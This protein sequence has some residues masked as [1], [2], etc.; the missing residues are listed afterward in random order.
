ME[1]VIRKTDSREKKIVPMARQLQDKDF[2]TK[3]KVVVAVQYSGSTV[4]R[5]PLSKPCFFSPSH[6]SW[7]NILCASH[8]I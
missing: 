8:V 6:L 4:Y 2:G 3:E 1:I 5:L 7:F